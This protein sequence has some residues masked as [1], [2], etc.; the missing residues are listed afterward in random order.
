MHRQRQLGHHGGGLYRNGSTTTLTN[1]TVSGNTASN[2]RRHVQRRHGDP[3]QHHRGGEHGQRSAGPMRSGPCLP[4]PQPD[5]RD[6]RQLRLGRL[7]PDRHRRQPLNALLAPLGNYG[8]PTQTMAL[9][10]GSPAID[11]GN[12]ALIPAGITTDQRGLPASE[13]HRRHRRLRGPVRSRWSSTRPPTASP[14]R[15]ASSTCA[16]RSS[17]ANVLPGP[18]D[19]LRPDRLRHAQT[20]TLTGGQLELSNT[21]GTET[22]TGPAAGVTV[23]GGGLAGCSRSTAVS[24]RRLGTDDHGRHATNGTA[25]ACT[26]TGHVTLTDCTVSGNSAAAAA[27]A[28]WTTTD[29]VDHQLHGHRQHRQLAGGG[30]D[31]RQHDHAHRLHRQRQLRRRRRRWSGSARSR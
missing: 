2:W 6:R 18:H 13:Q 23:S 4:G 21:S 11:A 31:Q 29:T 1:C 9:L 22:I 7:R 16:R 14:A 15:S 8:G 28:A 19:H 5:R 3:R 26:T 30:I 27:A 12:N 24:R 10:P 17:L 25:A 20:I